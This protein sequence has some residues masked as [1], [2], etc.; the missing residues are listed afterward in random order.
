M[1]FRVDADKAKPGLKGN[2][3]L[4]AFLERKVQ[5]K[6]KKVPAKVRR[7][8]VGSLPALSFEVLDR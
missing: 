1:A 5:G 4:K 7:W 3:I 8:Q 6:D 2:L